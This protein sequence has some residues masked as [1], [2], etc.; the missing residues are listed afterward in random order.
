MSRRGSGLRGVNN[1][2]RLLRRLPDEVS[3]EVRDEVREAAELIE[4]DAKRL[5]HKDSGD[6]AASISHKLGRDKMS[7]QIGF[8]SKWK[9]LW[10][11]AGW[12]AA[13]EE[14]GTSRQRAHPFL[15]PAWEMNRADITKRIAKAINNTLDRLAFYKSR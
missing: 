10:R 8:S 2:R 13:F 3:Q 15:F 5:V 6:L 11:Q 12:R 14:L 9:R 1:F 7:A 4:Y